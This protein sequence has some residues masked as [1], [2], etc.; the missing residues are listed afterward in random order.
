MDIIMNYRFFNIFLN[1]FFLA[2]LSSFLYAQ[3]STK[4]E[5]AEKKEQP[6]KH[7]QHFIDED[8][9][10]YNDNAPDHDGDGIPNGLDPDWKRHNEEKKRG[11]QHRFVDLDGDGINDNIYTEEDPNKGQGQNLQG[12]KEGS[13]LEKKTKE[14]QQKQQKKQHGKP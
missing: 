1:V 4:A 5:K 13:S 9:D 14:Q 6:V 7:Q 12:Q 2:I 11:K 3:D 8:G 10:G